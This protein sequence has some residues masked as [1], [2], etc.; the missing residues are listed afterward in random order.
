ME[1]WLYC[2]HFYLLILQVKNFRYTA[3][4]FTWNGM[5]RSLQER[6]LEES[7]REVR[8]GKL[9]KELQSA[10]G[11]EK[12]SVITGARWRH[13]IVWSVYKVDNPRPVSR[14][15]QK[16]FGPKASFR[17]K[18]CWTEAQFLAHKPANFASVVNWWFYCIIFKNYLK[19]NTKQL[20]G[21]E[22]LSEFEL[23]RGA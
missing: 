21:P 8:N 4:P 2:S 5:M 16:H 9:A 10:K 20:S 3:R 14:K 22:K 12:L 1:V 13:S 15:A 23:S 6:Y 17:I 18:T 7:V 19:A 11:L